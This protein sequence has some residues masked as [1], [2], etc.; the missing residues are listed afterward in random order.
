MF[1]N[2]TKLPQQESTGKWQTGPILPN[3]GNISA[4]LKLGLVCATKSIKA[5]QLVIAEEVQSR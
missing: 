4:I 5:S 3:Q 1:H 2:Q